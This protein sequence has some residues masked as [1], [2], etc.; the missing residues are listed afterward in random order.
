[1]SR[2]KT[3]EELRS[4]RWY[5]VDDLRA[6]GHRSRTKQMGFEERDFAG[7][8]VIAVINTW[9]DL[10]PCH[11]HFRQWAEEVKR[12][13]WQAGGFPVELLTM[14][15]GENLVKPTT[16]LYRNFLAMEVEELLR[17]HPVDG[18]VLMGGCDKTTPG[19]LMGAI[20][21]DIPA[22]YLPAGP[23]LS[24]N[25]RGEKLGSGSDVWKYW[26]ARRAGEIDQATW[27]EMEDGIARFAGTCMTMGT[28]MTGAAEALGL[29]LAG[30]SSIPASDSNHAR[31]AA[32]S[33]RRAVEMVW[34]DLKPSDILTRDA[35]VNA[36]KMVLAMGGSTNATIHVVAM[37]RR[38]GVDLSL[39]DFDRLAGEVP[40]LANVRPAGAYLMEDFYY[41]GGIRALMGRL[42][43]LFECEARTVA[44]GALRDNWAGVSAYDD[45]VIRP[46][47]NP[48][49]HEPALAVLKGTLAPDAR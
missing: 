15:R 35:V 34:E 14:S 37:A 21:M 31:L 47:D 13:V 6:F 30:A 25:C 28:A 46:R 16:M 45:D 41:A 42:A 20:S 18:A 7:K 5:G 2:R 8:P 44:G 40:L 36:I 48:V 12:G 23:M 17:G 22:S 9:S 43:D 29:T 3:P 4:H 39:D 32:A 38:A 49:S 10:N 1:M 27:N 24:G 26:D 11:M 19:L 33:G